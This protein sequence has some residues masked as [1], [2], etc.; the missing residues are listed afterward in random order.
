M[1]LSW[2]LLAR[3]LEAFGVTG[4]LAVVVLGAA[5]GVLFGQ[6]LGEHLDT[7]I[8]EKVVEVVLAILLFVDATEVRRG[9]LGGE[10]RLVARLLAVA[11]PLSLCA[12][13]G[14]GAL[15][16]PGAPWA[17]IL[18]VACIVI[19][20]DFAA[21]AAMLRDER[22]PGTVR[23]TLN[24]ESGYNDG[25]VSPLFVFALALA[26]GTNAAAEPISA[27]EAAVT[28]SVVAVVVGLVIGAAS[29]FAVRRAADVKW[30]TAQ[31]LRV[32]VVVIPLLV[33]VVSLPLNG[34][35]FVAAFVAG[36]A[37]RTTRV[38]RRSGA[39]TIDH[40]E[41]TAV[42]DV[43]A[44]TSLGVWFVFGA[45]TVLT[46]EAGFDWSLI[47]LG[48][49]ALTALRMLPVYLAL[50]GS[51][52]TWRERTVIGLS[53]PRGTASIVFGLLAFNVL[54]EDYANTTLYV[55]VVVVLGSVILHGAIVPRLAVSLLGPAPGP[56]PAPDA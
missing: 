46:F 51:S 39:G 24:V 34:N 20:T 35:G 1:I 25:I 7:E 44:V 28:A 26:G 30:V 11:L 16:I 6:D 13:V 53:G 48:L 14:A 32:G 27:I 2:S 22:L 18:L 12:A 3:R 45:A 9:F 4:P 49:L 50:L 17:V 37:F 55:T 23:N 15:L 42:D 38:A 52:A 43:G 36:I 47:V 10:G 40:R 19:P 5:S 41:M 56:A 8:A 31:S 21:S 29:G 33:Y 54:R